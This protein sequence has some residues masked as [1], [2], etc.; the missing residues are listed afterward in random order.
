MYDDGRYFTVTGYHLPGTPK[1]V[2]ER[3]REL[4]A[5]H[6]RV[7]GPARTPVAVRSS[8]P[9]DLDDR[10]LIERARKGDAFGRL[11]R[12]DVSAY[13]NN[14]SNAD[15]ALCTRLAYWTGGDP[16]RID[17][18]FRQSGLMRAKWD[19]RHAS[20]GRTYGQITVAKAVESEQA[21]LFP[22][23]QS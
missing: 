9:V 12:G 22:Q 13:A 17:R 21:G 10:A 20:D 3:S 5:L 15:L 23:L 19:E 18:L 14:H 2:K 11:W 4:A 8:T 6:R 1:T 16:A 7:F